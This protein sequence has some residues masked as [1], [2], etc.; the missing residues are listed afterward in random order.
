MNAWFQ[1]FCYYQR[2]REKWICWSTHD[3]GFRSSLL[4]S[5]GARVKQGKRPNLSFI[6]WKRIL[7]ISA[8]SMITVET[9]HWLFFF[10]NRT[11]DPCS[12]V[13]PRRPISSKAT[14][15]V[16]YLNFDRSF[17]S[18]R[19][20]INFGFYL[21]TPFSEYFRSGRMYRSHSQRVL[22]EKENVSASN[23]SSTSCRRMRIK[24]ISLCND[25]RF[26]QE[27]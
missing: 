9:R 21:K 25:T 24:I 6:V 19:I 15:D 8:C 5:R 20:F 13:A 1:N 22:I 4:E 27:S 3:R 7:L 10:F 11:D 2:E 14:N 17:H 26:C 18:I 16:G 23:Y 12:S